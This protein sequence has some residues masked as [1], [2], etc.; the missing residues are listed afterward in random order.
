MTV[1]PASS[2]AQPTTLAVHLWRTSAVMLC[3]VPFAM[4]VANRSSPTFLGLSAVFALFALAAERQVPVFLAHVRKVLRSP[5]GIA[6]LVFFGWTVVSLAWSGVPLLSLLALGEFWLPIVAAFI[7]ALTL[8]KR[9]PSLGILL[10]ALSIAAACFLILLELGTG[11][12]LRRAFGLRAATFIFNRPALTILVLLLP[13]FFW[14]Q[15]LPWKHPYRWGVAAVSALAVLTIMISESG[16]AKLGVVAAAL[17]YSLARWWPRFALALA[18]L[19]VVVGVLIAPLTGSLGD[20][21]IPPSVHQ[22]LKNS[23][24]RERV[25]VWLSFE[26]AV[27]K[28]GIVGGGFAVSPRLADMPVAQELSLRQRRLLRMGHPHNAALQIWIELGAIG[29]AL[30][31]VVLLLILKALNERPVEQ[32]APRLALFGAVG[33]ISLVAHGAWQGWWI[34]AIGAAIIMFQTTDLAKADPAE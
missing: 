11:L 16:A 32:L 20:A 9:M 17:T 27:A 7:L 29:A 21:F 13:L 5:L 1:S 12:T 8:P 14:S 3:L 18:A 24:S 4:A 30:A 28:Q 22:Y 2:H 10:L 19:S 6:V 34:A 25:D 31:I 26:A 33:A 15:T 23:H